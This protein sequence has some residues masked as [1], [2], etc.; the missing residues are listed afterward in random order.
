[1]TIYFFESI[2]ESNR[3]IRY[4][5]FDDQY[6]R[7]FTFDDQHDVY[8]MLSTQFR[9]SYVYSAIRDQFEYNYHFD[10]SSFQ[11]SS[12]DIVSIRAFKFA[13]ISQLFRVENQHARFVF[14]FAFVSN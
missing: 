7:F 9:S 12:F 3:Y 1:M 10:F 11:F 14:L 5:I 8:L 4:V 13:T 2:V 6:I